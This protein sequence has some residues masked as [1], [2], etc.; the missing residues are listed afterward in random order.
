MLKALGFLPSIEKEKGLEL[1][2]YPNSLASKVV[3]VHKENGWACVYND[4]YSLSPV[5]VCIHTALLPYIH[6]FRGN[7]WL[8][9]IGM[10]TDGTNISFYQYFSVEFYLLNL[11]FIQAKIFKYLI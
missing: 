2:V 6:T 8:M 11:H 5:A 1:V 4:V 10:P 3:I 7:A 9:P